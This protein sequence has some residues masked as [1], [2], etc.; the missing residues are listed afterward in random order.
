MA[1]KIGLW[2][3]RNIPDSIM[4]SPINPWAKEHDDPIPPK[5]TFRQYYER[6][7]NE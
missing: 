4:E 1:E 2:A 3:L 5:E 6:N 7:I